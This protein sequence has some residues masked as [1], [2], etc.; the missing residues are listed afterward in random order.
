MKSTPLNSNPEPLSLW[1]VKIGPCDTKR[2]KWVI[3][4]AATNVEY[5]KRLAGQ[6]IGQN[7]PSHVKRIDG[8]PCANCE[9]ACSVSRLGSG[10]VSPYV[11]AVSLVN[12]LILYDPDLQ[13]VERVA[14]SQTNHSAFP[15]WA[16]TLEE[17][18]YPLYVIANNF[19]SAGD[20]AKKWMKEVSFEDERM[21]ADIRQDLYE[22]G[23]ETVSED[24]IIR[25][26]KPLLENGFAEEG[27]FEDIFEV[28]VTSVK[29]ID[30]FVVM[31]EMNPAENP[32]SAIPMTDSQSG[33]G[34]TK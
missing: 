8:I 33:S 28:S 13:V 31:D 16:V 9:E 19:A 3:H 12:G 5:A 15:L 27:L 6:W 1:N 11:A 4:V 22:E 25:G 17:H 24:E 2:N 30:S 10:S 14:M 21:E 23:L 34:S 18:P 32:K 29:R 20:I 7:L 26:A